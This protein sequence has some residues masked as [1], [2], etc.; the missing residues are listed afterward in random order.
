MNKSIVIIALLL[1][2][3]MA[4]PLQ[5]KFEIDLESGG[6]FSGYNDVRIPGDAGTLF[7]L[8]EATES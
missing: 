3:L 7:S 5:A 1:L 8:S 4:L 2:T 6:V